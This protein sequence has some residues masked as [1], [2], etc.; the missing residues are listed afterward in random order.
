[1]ERFESCREWDEDE[2]WVYRR[3]FVND[4][5]T[6]LRDVTVNNDDVYEYTKTLT[7][8]QE[9]LTVNGDDVYVY[10]DMKFWTYFILYCCLFVCSV[11]HRPFVRLLDTVD[12]GERGLRLAE[13]ALNLRC[14]DLCEE[15]VCTSRNTVVFASKSFGCVR[16]FDLGILFIARSISSSFVI[17]KLFR[18]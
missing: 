3:Y 5:D 18:L 6:S 14:R 2:Q 12:D 9:I 17:R 8:D 13:T 10:V 4:W 11:Y 16:Y 7:I 15:I 1:M